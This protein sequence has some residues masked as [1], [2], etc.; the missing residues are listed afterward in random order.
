MKQKESVDSRPRL[1]KI[2]HMGLLHN[3]RTYL[4][5]NLEFSDSP[6]PWRQRVKDVLQPV[7]VKILS[8]MEEMFVGQNS[9][10]PE[11]QEWLKEER[12]RGHWEVVEDYMKGVIEKDLR[13]VDCSD[14][15]IFNIETTKPTFG[16]THELVVAT[17]QH[18][19]IF[20]AVGDVRN[21]PLWLLGLVKRKN[22]FNNIEEILDILVKI[23]DGEIELNSKKWKL[24]I[25]TLR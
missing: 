5:G 2:V 15:C 16:T 4:A 23:D 14:F 11:I 3:T 6:F 13:L 12:S 7:G 10:T 22:L 25:E 21:T 19:P 8:P 1:D 20:V 24:L 17:Q 18:K 9:E